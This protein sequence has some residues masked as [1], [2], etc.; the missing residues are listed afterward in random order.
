MSEEL[1]NFLSH[2]GV[3]GM[4]WGH[5][6]SIET[7][8]NLRF[9]GPPTT[10]NIDHNLHA[11]TKAASKEVA[12]L[13]AQRYKFNITDVKSIGPGHP[14]YE[15]GTMGYVKLGSGK[16]NEGTIFVSKDHLRPMLKASEDMGWLG[17]DCGTEQSFLTHE[18]AHA[19]F[20]APVRNVQGLLGVR[21]VGGNID[22]RNIAMHEAI[23]A[24][25]KEGI[26]E[27]QF[28]DRISGYAST[29]GIREEAEAEM[30]SQYHWGSNS[31]NFVKVWGE[32]LHRE[33]GVDP[34]PFKEMR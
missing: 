24:S 27:H 16:V 14:E 28:L 19:I 20:H 6:K 15:A 13:I 1:D 7:T 4:Q 30:F 34:T 23:K 12:S 33:M 21:Q 2:Y 22:A 32:T 8:G 5:R 31:P 26:P 17:K 25:L 10:V 9:Q 18:T 29:A 11:D 3:R